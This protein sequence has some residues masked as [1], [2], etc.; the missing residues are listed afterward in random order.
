MALDGLQ[1][2]ANVGSGTDQLAGRVVGG[3]FAGAVILVDENGLE[4]SGAN[5]LDVA[6]AAPVEIANDSGNPIPVSG[7]VKLAT[8]NGADVTVANPLPVEIDGTINV[9]QADAASSGN[10]S[11]VGSTVT[12]SLN[13]MASLAIQMRASTVPAFAGTI[14]FE[15]TVNGTDWESIRGF[16]AG[17]VGESYTQVDQTLVNNIFRFTVAGFSQVRARLSTLTLG[18]ADV[19]MRASAPTSTVFA[20]SAVPVLTQRRDANTTPVADGENARFFSDETGRLKVSTHPGSYDIVTGNITANGQTAVCPCSRGS[21]IIAHMVATSLVGHNATFEGS[22]DSTNGTDGAWFAIDAKRT[23]A[24]TVELVTGVLAATPAYAWELSVNGFKYIRV[25]ATAHTSGTAAWK[26]QQ[27]PYATEPIPASQVSGTQPVSGT[28]TATVTGGTVLPVTP[29]TTFTNSAASTN[30]TSIKASA[31]TLWSAIVSN[32]NA[33]TRY[34]KFYNLATAP[35]V[36]TSTPVFTVAVPSG[37]TV[38]VTGGSNGIRFA[39]GIGL[40]ITA[41]AA[42]SDTAAVAAGDVKVATSFT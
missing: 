35:T 8:S 25:R 10:L 22:I 34:V 7:T 5:P 21:N 6:L 41:G 32:I 39:T 13:A 30:P 33:S 16:Y 29:T 2:K 28:V 19:W 18:N 14:M 42:D 23:N 20:A 40:A 4:I 3:K 15:G 26:F 36:G 37:G 1:A 11:I 12:V 17:S 38:T 31:G 27:A 9:N 24:N